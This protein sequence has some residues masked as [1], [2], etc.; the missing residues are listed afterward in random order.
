MKEKHINEK[1]LHWQKITAYC[2]YQERCHKEVREK[3]YAL[4]LYKNDVEQFDEIAP[5]TEIHLLTSAPEHVIN[6]VEYAD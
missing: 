1:D 3:L 6:V 2:A 5:T 4:G